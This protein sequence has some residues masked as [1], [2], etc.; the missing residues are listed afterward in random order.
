MRDHQQV[1]RHLQSRLLH[2]ETAVRAQPVGCESNTEMFVARRQVAVDIERE[3]VG[4]HIFHVVRGR[5]GNAESRPDRQFIPLDY[6]GIHYVPQ[7][8]RESRV[9]P[10]RFLNEAVSNIDSGRGEVLYVRIAVVE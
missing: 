6:T 2:A 5:L 1:D 7:G 4:K 3:G 8:R 9:H 10:Q